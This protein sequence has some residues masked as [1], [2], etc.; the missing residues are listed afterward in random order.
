MNKGNFKAILF[1]L[2]TALLVVRFTSNL[3]QRAARA[4]PDK[5]SDA[6]LSE[7]FTLIWQVLRWSGPYLAP[8]GTY[9]L[10]RYTS[11]PTP[12]GP[13][14]LLPGQ[15]LRVVREAGA[16]VIVTASAVAGSRELDVPRS[17][18]TDDL[19]LA[20]NLALRDWSAHEE[21]RNQVEADDASRER[22]RAQ[23]YQ[24]AAADLA[25]AERNRTGVGGSSLGGR[26]TVLNH[27]PTSA[28]GYSSYPLS[29]PYVVTSGSGTAGSS[30]PATGGITLGN[31]AAAHAAAASQPAYTT[32]RPGTPPTADTQTTVKPTPALNSGNLGR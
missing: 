15:E 25:S 17:S 27:G 8:E 31:S 7:H 26:Q 16:R 20:R 13:I 14:G 2:V 21:F 18:M 4:F 6:T 11:V 3:R 12:T 24:Q 22:T 32:W 23:L 5:F 1:L 29:F 10:T 28:G 9:Y 30:N 19:D